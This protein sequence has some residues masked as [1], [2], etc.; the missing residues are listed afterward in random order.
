MGTGGLIEGRRSYV[1]GRW[2]DPER[3][4]AVEDPAAETVVADAG[5]TPLAQVERAITAASEAFA[6]G[7]G[8]WAC[9]PAR[10]RAA[11]LGVLLDHLEANRETLIATMI[12][13]A[14]QPRM[15]AE[16]S[17]LGMGMGLARSTIDLYLSLPEE[18]RNPVPLDELVRGRVALS[19]R[20]YEPVGVVSAI[21]PYN[22]AVIM[23]FQKLIPALMAGN[24]VVLRPSPLTPLSS[25]AFA[26]AAEAAELPAGVLSVVVDEGSDGGPTLMLP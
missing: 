1:A 5:V 12:A 17:Q 22:G 14:G 16:G 10:D 13:E 6:D 7:A 24:S 18:E 2:V 25:L 11:R 4:F 23:A 9:L 26:E 3:T 8:P 15:F 21:T 20:R 19:V